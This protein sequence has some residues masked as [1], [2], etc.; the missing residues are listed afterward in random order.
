EAASVEQGP[1]GAVAP[2]AEAQPRATPRSCSS[3]RHTPKTR[4][5]SPA[6]TSARRWKRLSVKESAL[7]MSRVRITLAS[8]PSGETRPGTRSSRARGHETS[9]EHEPAALL[10]QTTG[11]LV[12]Q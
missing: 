5:G 12:E 2:V 3:L 9:A 8:S 11:R 7:S 6:I 1:D 10:C 4:T